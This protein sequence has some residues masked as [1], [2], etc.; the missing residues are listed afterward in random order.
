M[1]RYLDPKSDLTFKKIFL[2]YLYLLK[3]ILNAV[4][5]LLVYCLI[6]TLCYLS[7]E[8]VP[9]TPIAKYSIVD[10]RCFD[11]HGR[12]FIVEM[13]IDWTPDFIQRMLFNA[14]STYVKQID[15]GKE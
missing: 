9:R 11:N 1:A 4:L 8:N 10:V 2:F 12:Q 6:D 7:P 13:Q 5:P 14:A 15:K 3:S